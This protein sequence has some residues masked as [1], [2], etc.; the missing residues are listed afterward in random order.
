MTISSLTGKTSSTS[1]PTFPRRKAL[2]YGPSRITLTGRQQTVD[3]LFAAPSPRHLLP[4]NC[5]GPKLP[6]M[7]R[8]VFL[9]AINCEGARI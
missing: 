9:G 1:S 3:R 8:N 7:F 2:A 6:R 4:L 5:T